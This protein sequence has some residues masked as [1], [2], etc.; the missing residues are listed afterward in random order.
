MTLT[1]LTFLLLAAPDPRFAAS[2]V[3]YSDLGFGVYGDPGAVLGKPATWIRDVVNGGPE[4]RVAVSWGYPAWDTDPD[5]RPVVVTVRPGGHITVSFDPPIMNDPRHWYGYDFIVYGNP[6]IGCDRGVSWDTDLANVRVTAGGD[7]IEPAA[8]S[9]SPDGVVWHTYPV[10]PYSGADAY[11]PTMAHLWN[12]QTK[13]WG[14]E[15]D[16][17][18]PVPPGWQR[19]LLVGLSLADVSDLLQGSAGGCAFDLAP[20][21]FKS[22]RFIKVTGSWS[23]VDG[24]SRVG[25]PTWPIRQQPRDH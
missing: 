6:V 14:P 9:V 20:S 13:G 16:W 21:G 7:F 23:E 4:E 22:I 2:V 3:S 12:R 15:S 8:V 10:G 18:K 1:S 11:W 24:F 19:S 5:G 17:T 25:R